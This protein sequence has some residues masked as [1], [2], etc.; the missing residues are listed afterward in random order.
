M[1]LPNWSR[2]LPEPIV[3]LDGSSLASL[4][5]AAGFLVTFPRDHKKM[6]WWRHAA[7][8]VTVAANRGTLDDLDAAARQ[9]RIALKA[10]EVL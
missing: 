6:P 9:L 10:A 2:H 8:L 5:D 1:C 7:H 3:L 4:D